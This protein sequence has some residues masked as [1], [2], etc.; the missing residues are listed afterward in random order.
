M[1]LLLRIVFSFVRGNKFLANI[2]WCTSWPLIS[3]FLL[4]F[5]FP[6]S[7]TN[8]VPGWMA[9]ACSTSLFAPFAAS[10]LTSTQLLGYKQEVILHRDG[11]Q[12]LPC[13]GTAWWVSPVGYHPTVPQHH[14]RD[15]WCQLVA[16]SSR[17]YCHSY[18]QAGHFQNISVGRSC[19][20]N[21][22]PFLRSLNHPLD[23]P[24]WFLSGLAGAGITQLLI[25]SLEAPKP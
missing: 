2:S 4:H 8:P 21:L 5:R 13:A 3:S 23:T 24:S 15:L 16:C 22:A 20:P 11:C 18:W 1:I 12:T 17:H 6:A 7:E 14:H 9:L 10:L 25:S 19:I